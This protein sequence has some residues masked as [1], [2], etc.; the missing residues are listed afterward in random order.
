LWRLPTTTLWHID[1]VSWGRPLHPTVRRHCEER[2]RRSNPDCHSCE[3]LDCFAIARN[4]AWRYS[5]DA[6]CAQVG[7]LLCPGEGA[8]NAGCSMHP[9]P[10]VRNEK[11]HKRSYH[12]H[13][14]NARHSPRNGFNG[15]LRALSG[16]RAFLPPSPADRSADLMPAS[17][18]Q[19]HTT[20]P[21]VGRARS[22]L[23]PSTSTASRPAF[24]DDREPLLWDET[25]L[26]CKD[27]L[28]DGQ[29]GKF[30]REGLDS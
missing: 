24:R 30:F 22:S 11:A 26:A 9:Q 17:R 12:G 28:P 10:C 4:D 21:S 20:S 6:S 8:G 19:D 3:S 13:T 27:D 18:H 16:D 1:A 23:A 15:L 29:S 7:R 14:G 25:A 5:R 2:Q